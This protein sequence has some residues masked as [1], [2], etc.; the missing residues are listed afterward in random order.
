[1]VLQ[2]IAG[3]TR[4][5]K[6]TV[7]PDQLRRQWREASGDHLSVVKDVIARADGRRREIKRITTEGAL[8]LGQ[9]QV[10]ERNSVIDERALLREALIY[11]RGDVQLGELRREIEAR[12]K[13]GDLIRQGDEI[14]SREDAHHGTRV[15]GL[16]FDV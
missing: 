2:R 16:D 8:D 5:E 14:V 4:A 7:E 11:G 10:F 3:S 15:P 13:K 6:V 1:M 9:S 12:I